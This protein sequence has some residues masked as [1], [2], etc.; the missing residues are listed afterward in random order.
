MPRRRP[1]RRGIAATEAAICIPIVVLLTFATLEISSA[2]FL[3]ETL[4]VAAYE[5]A[6][7][8]VKKGATADDVRTKVSSVLQARGIT[9]IRPSDLWVNVSPSDLSTTRALDPVSVQV[10]L[11][12][13]S[14]VPFIDRFFVRTRMR[15]TAVMAREFDN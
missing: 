3:K 5:G 1:S 4:T 7:V 6:R 10:D 15:G 14:Y 11:P 8:G 9:A 13:A 2:I 12:M